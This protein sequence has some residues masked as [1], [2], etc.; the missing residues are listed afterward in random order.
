MITEEE[1]HNI[2][3]KQIP[4][5]ILSYE[6]PR[7]GNNH[8]MKVQLTDKYIQTV[9]VDIDFNL[10]N[11]RVIPEKLIGFNVYGKYDNQNNPQ[12]LKYK[13]KEKSS[14]AF[15]IIMSLIKRSSP[16]SDFDITPFYNYMGMKIEN[17][18][19]RSKYMINGVICTLFIIRD[20]QGS[21]NLIIDNI[22]PHSQYKGQLFIR[23]TDVKEKSYTITNDFNRLPTTYNE[24]DFV[25]KPLVKPIKKNVTIKLDDSS[26]F[27]VMNKSKPKPKHNSM[28][29]EQRL[30]YS[31]AAKKETHFEDD[32]VFPTLKQFSAIQSDGDT[33]DVGGG[34]GAAVDIG[35]DDVVV[36]AASA[37]SAATAAD[38]TTV[39]SIPT[40]TSADPVSSNGKSNTEC[41]QSVINDVDGISDD[42]VIG[43]SDANGDDTTLSA[44]DGNA[45]GDATTISADD[46]DVISDDTVIIPNSDLNSPHAI[47]YTNR[48]KSP[49]TLNMVQETINRMEDAVSTESVF[50]SQV[51]DSTKT[52]YYNKFSK[53][54]LPKAPI[55]MQAQYPWVKDWHRKYAIWHYDFTQW[56]TD[57]EEDIK[58]FNTSKIPE[59]EYDLHPMIYSSED[60]PMFKPWHQNYKSWYDQFVQWI[61]DNELICI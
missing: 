46:G 43:T 44:D 3:D 23:M 45:N 41:D 21:P 25:M 40:K 26:S 53:K 29:E 42:E 57:Y 55:P 31:D 38:A 9:I 17:P 16:T 61:I 52:D 7:E 11:L 32:N 1:L 50:N 34:A 13:S 60:D 10:I 15:S 30:S 5:K 59:I 12:Y 27:P 51:D 2:F 56:K 37:T 33:I 36:S 14:A 4:C 18:D 47:T 35:T 28:S 8:L 20:I 24:S 22:T 58:E 54:K 48:N 49:A 39:E 19:S 6:K